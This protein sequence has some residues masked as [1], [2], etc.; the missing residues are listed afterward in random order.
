MRPGARHSGHRRGLARLPRA[1]VR[2]RLLRATGAPTP[3]AASSRTR[4]STPCRSASMRPPGRS[5]AA[6][7]ARRARAWASCRS[8]SGPTLMFALGWLVLRKII[9]ISKENRITSIADFVASQVRQEHPA[10]WPRDGH[11]RGRDRAVHRAPAEGGLGHVQHPHRLPADQ[12]A[13]RHRSRR[14]C[15][16]TRR[17]TSRCCS[18]PSRSCSAP[19]GSTRASAT[20]AW[21]RPSRS[22]RSSSWSP[23]SPSGCS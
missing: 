22:S 19:A 4:P 14:R 18:P 23:S 12:L 3:G 2:R 11:R 7:A 17:S 10:R 13:D 8:T 20:R 9:R 6:S 21:S 1:A 15:S 16:R 5:T